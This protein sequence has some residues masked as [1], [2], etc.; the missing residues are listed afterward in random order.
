MSGV[1]VNVEP[2]SERRQRIIIIIIIII[3]HLIY[4]ALSG[5]PRTLNKVEQT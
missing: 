1:A 3:M 4:I 2:S 5:Y